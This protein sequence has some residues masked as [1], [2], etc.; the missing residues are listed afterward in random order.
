MN[1]GQSFKKY[2]YISVLARLLLD[3]AL[4][5][6]YFLALDRIF[7]Y[8]KD[9]LLNVYCIKYSSVKKLLSSM[10][11]LCACPFKTLKDGA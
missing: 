8:K 4:K 5:V 10:C 3:D 9:W 1:L 7:V 6:F 2:I 11:H